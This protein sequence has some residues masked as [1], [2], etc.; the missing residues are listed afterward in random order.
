MNDAIDT[1]DV[2]VSRKVNF[3]VNL[4]SK[5]KI[6]SI[7]INTCNVLCDKDIVYAPYLVN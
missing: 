2:R 5:K 7:E 1:T 3:A 6:I 4:S